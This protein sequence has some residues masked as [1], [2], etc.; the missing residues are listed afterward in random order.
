MS[1]AMPSILVID[2]NTAVLEAMDCFLRAQGY[3]VLLAENG[4]AGLRLA[5]RQH[6]DLVLLDIEMPQMSGLEVCR[7][8]RAD[9]AL[10]HLP[11]LIMTGRPTRDC[12]LRGREAGASLVV[13][14]PFDLTR[15]QSVIAG[16]LSA[17]AAPPSAAP[18]A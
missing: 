8:I 11:V 16:L 17:A 6:V 4:P 10:R 5:A 15:L 18:P 9:P 3:A 12:F 1:S 2:D 7:L 13:G 14:K